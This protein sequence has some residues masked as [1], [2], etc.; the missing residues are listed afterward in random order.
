MRRLLVLAALLSSA[1]DSGFSDSPDGFSCVSGATLTATA[2]TE[3]YTAECIEVNASSSGLTV[4][5]YVN[6][7]TDRNE[8]KR[9]VEFVVASRSVGTYPVSGATFMSYTTSPVVNGTPTSTTLVASGTGQVVITESTGSRVRGTFSF[10]GREE[11]T[12]AGGTTPTPGETITVTGS[13]D[14][15]I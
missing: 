1:C 2:G 7:N 15:P 14:V 4:R 13:F 8:A 10:T 9:S 5:S 12:P 11:T 3:A 6:P